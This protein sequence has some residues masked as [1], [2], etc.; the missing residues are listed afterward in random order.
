[1]GYAQRKRRALAHDLLQHGR[2]MAREERVKGWDNN[3]VI[4]TPSA[5][6]WVCSRKRIERQP[7]F[8][9]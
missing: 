6:L 1:M 8:N 2:L 3:A 5:H 4:A 9:E 7:I